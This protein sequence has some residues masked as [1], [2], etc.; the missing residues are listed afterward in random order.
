MKKRVE[1][2]NQ[3][4]F[5]ACIKAGN[6]A[7]VFGQQAGGDAMK[8]LK[9]PPRVLLIFGALYI[10]GNAIMLCLFGISVAFGLC[11]ILSS[12]VMAMLIWDKGGAK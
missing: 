11:L 2:R 5:E 3:A 9:R 10:L 6:I 4:E 7:L 12:G 8:R 1:V